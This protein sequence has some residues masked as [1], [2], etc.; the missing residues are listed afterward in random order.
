[1][2]GTTIFATMQTSNFD[3]GHTSRQFRKSRLAIASQNTKERLGFFYFWI[4]CV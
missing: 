3:C 2:L 1:M 4:W